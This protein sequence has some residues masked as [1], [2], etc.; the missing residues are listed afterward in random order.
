MAVRFKVSVNT[1]RRYATDPK[2]RRR[3]IAYPT[4]SASLK[5]RHRAMGPAAKNGTPHAGQSRLR[6]RM[7]AIRRR[8]EGKPPRQAIHRTMRG[9]SMDG[10]PLPCPGRRSLHIAKNTGKTDDV[11][12]LRLKS[13]RPDCS[14]DNA[15]PPLIT[16]VTRSRS[17]KARFTWSPG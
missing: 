3:A 9:M 12:P 14:G 8:R 15:L 7:S 4:E 2:P 17:N 6:M 5:A 13:S 16:W 1:L 11:R 10:A